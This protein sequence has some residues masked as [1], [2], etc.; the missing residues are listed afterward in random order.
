[1]SERGIHI[2]SASIL[3]PRLIRGGE[4]SYRGDPIA[5]KHTTGR[6]TPLHSK[7]GT[8]WAALPPPALTCPFL[9]SR[10]AWSCGGVDS[11][12]ES[13][14]RVGWLA[15]V[16]AIIEIG[17]CNFGL[18]PRFSQRIVIIF[19]QAPLSLPLPPTVPQPATRSS[20]FVFENTF[21]LNEVKPPQCSSLSSSLL[22]SWARLRRRVIILRS[23]ISTLT[24]L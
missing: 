10:S 16:S 14:L 1:M 3:R 5:P 6:K 21:L 2:Y 7:G 9:V 11:V 23:T 18:C 8:S 19:A 20:T 13:W 24:P 15:S 17:F 22:P 12:L 4:V